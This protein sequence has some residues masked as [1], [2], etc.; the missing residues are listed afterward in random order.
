VYDAGNN[1]GLIMEM[2]ADE[3]AGKIVSP[4]IFASGWALSYPGSWMADSM[5]GIGV[6]E[7]D[8]AV[9]AMDKQIAAKPDLQKFTMERFGVGPSPLG[10]TFP[11]ELIQKMLAYM[12]D[13]GVRTV[14]HVT[15]ESLARDASA[16]GLDAYA[17]PVASARM[18]EEFLQTLV[19]KQSPVATTLAVYDDLIKGQEESD[20]L[21]DPF[22]LEVVP[23]DEIEERK[24]AP[25]TPFGAFDRTT[26]FKLLNPYLREN[27]K[28]LH[29][30]GGVV[31]LATDRSEGPMLHRELAL[32]AE[33][34]IPPAD[35][36][37]IGT[38]NGAKFLGREKDLGTLDVGKLADMVLLKADPTADVRNARQ[39]DTVIK[40]GAIIDRTKLQVQINR[41]K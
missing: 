22:T 5:K 36:I 26:W 38:L 15:T 28:R 37:R 25:P 34:G 33:I 10:P 2:R 19:K 30:A 31:V 29:D 1:P 23:R 4:R 7:W 18:S 13:H 16:A 8:E 17:H 6:A 12:H 32:L 20:Y 39:I 14:M 9:K 40:G 24:K 35:I 27:I 11:L 3:R 41:D 21:E